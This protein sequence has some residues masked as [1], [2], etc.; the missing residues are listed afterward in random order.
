MV[1]ATRKTKF[2]HLMC[3]GLQMVG[4]WRQCL[5]VKI[6]EKTRISLEYGI[7]LL[8]Q[9]E[10]VGWK[11]QIKIWVVRINVQN[12]L[13]Y[14]VALNI[15]LLVTEP[16]RF[17]RKKEW[18]KNKKTPEKICIISII[19]IILAQWPMKSFKQVELDERPTS[20]PGWSAPRYL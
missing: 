1:L 6:D 5:K 20:P 14:S 16:C 13:K 17:R 4:S 3:R 19:K 2:H 8:N 11:F 7:K 18:E 10:I 9:N 12:G 15:K